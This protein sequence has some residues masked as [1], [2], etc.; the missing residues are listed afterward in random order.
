MSKTEAYIGIKN[1]KDIAPNKSLRT[2]INPSKWDISK[3]N[4]KSN[5]SSA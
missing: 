2:L 4:S 5:I 1:H 3:I